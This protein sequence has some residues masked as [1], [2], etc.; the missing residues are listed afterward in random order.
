MPLGE[1]AVIIRYDISGEDRGHSLKIR[2]WRVYQALPSPNIRYLLFTYTL[3]TEQFDQPRSVEEMDL[4]DH[5][6]AAGLPGTPKE[7]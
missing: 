6:I 1:N 5:V 2:V 7:T 4:L 3:L